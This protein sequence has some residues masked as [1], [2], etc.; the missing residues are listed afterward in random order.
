MPFKS[1]DTKSRECS[2]FLQHMFAIELDSLLAIDNDPQR[3]KK[4]SFFIENGAQIRR[5]PVARGIA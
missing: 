2:I 1:F 3:N 4:Y 5:H